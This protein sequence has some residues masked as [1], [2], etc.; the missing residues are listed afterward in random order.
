[1]ED[2]NLVPLLFSVPTLPLIHSLNLPPP[3]RAFKIHVFFF[4]MAKHLIQTKLQ[5]NSGLVWCQRKT[6]CAGLACRKRSVPIKS[7][8]EETVATLPLELGPCV[9]YESA[10]ELRC[11]IC[12]TYGLCFAIFYNLIIVINTNFNIYTYSEQSD[13]LCADFSLSK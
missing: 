9:G 2:V 8:S 11:C 13:A 7:Q 1:M 3:P 6:D 12:Q 4:H 5:R 10:Y